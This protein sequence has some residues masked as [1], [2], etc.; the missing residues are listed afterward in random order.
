MKSFK[1]TRKYFSGYSLQ[2][3]IYFS[4]LLLLLCTFV[5]AQQVII[6][7]KV[8]VGDS[9]LADVTVSVRNS[10]IATKTNETGF[11]S[12]QVPSN[13][14]LVF[15]SVG[16]VTKEVRV[17]S[18]SVIN[19]ELEFQS[20]QLNDVIVVGYGTQ[21]KGNI[22]GSVSSIKSDE[23][24]RT[25]AS[26]TSSAIVGRVAGI[27]A[28]QATGRPGQGTSIQIRNLGTPLYV[29]DGVPQSEGQFNNVSSEDIESISI[30]KDGSAALYGVRASNGVVLVTT[31]KGKSGDKGKLSVNTYYQLQNLTRYLSASDAYTH[32]RASAEAQ[33][34]TNTLAN[35]GGINGGLVT[36]TPAELEKWR[37][38]TDSGYRSTNYR[39]Y[40]LQKNAPQKYIN[41]NASGGNDRMNYYVSL[42]ALSQEGIVN[43]FDFKRYN[44][45]T[46]VEGTII[47]GVKFGAQLNGRVEGRYNPA[48][49]TNADAYD[50]PFLAILTTWPMERIYANDN[51][52]YINGAVHRPDRNPANFDRNV[53][54]TQD[55]VWN[56]FGSIFYTTIEL[57]FGFSAKATYSYNYKQNKNEVFRKNF[58]IYTYDK[59]TGEYKV[60]TTQALLRRNKSRQEI[61]EN[62]TAFQL[63]YNKRI[64]K[65]TISATGAYEYATE[66]D[67]F[68]AITSSPA[69]N[70]L[71][72]IRTQDVTA[73]DNSYIETKR[74]SVIGRFNYD[75]R[76]RYLFEVL[77][78]YDGNYIYPPG[79]RWGLFPGVTGGWVLSEEK[80]YGDKLKG[81]MNY[82]KLRA[83]WGRTGNVVGV[84][85]FDYLIGG[86][87]PSGNYV[88]ADGSVINGV[89]I[90]SLPITNI[91]WVKSTIKNIGIQLGFFNHKLTAEF[92]AFSRDLTGIPA[93]KVDVVVPVEVGYTLPNE[94][95]DSDRTLGIEGTITYTNRIGEVNYSVSGNATLARRKNLERYKPRFGNSWDQ[96][97]NQSDHRWADINW[98]YEVTGQFQS[99]EEIK[100]Y[101]INNDGQGNTTQLPGDLK[102]RDVNGD[103]VITN[104]DER[105][106]GYGGNNGG[107]FGGNNPYMSFGLNMSF[108][109]K[110][111]GINLDWTGATLQSY[112]RIFESVVP[113]QATH[114]GPEYLFND[115][116]HRE[117]LYDNN[118]AW[119][120]G[121]YPAIRRINNHINYT[122]RSDFWI[123][124]ISYLRLR[125][126]ELVYNLPK[127]ILSRVHLSGA[128][129]YVTGTNILTFD[130]MKDIEL[131]PEIGQNNGLVYP[132]MKLYTFGINL[133]L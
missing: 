78:R 69:N 126:L 39:D 28:R 75:Y 63:N 64:G 1:L 74:G 109:Y 117:D 91:T 20:L 16:F 70:Y 9:A 57:P 83:S 99:V 43:Q 100:N 81:I 119:L 79:K 30:L 23:I 112:Y 12:I 94:N 102:F 114:N 25:P 34:N 72:V 59:T 47:K 82:V 37:L 40:I 128:K 17:G 73:I 110:G 60:K 62:F 31:R 104:L 32:M 19:T 95:L 116:W 54:G 67:E 18:S 124:N 36:I 129:V 26:T 121:K 108:S 27:T 50:N 2:K 105:P 77:G 65:H 49:T 5:S 46:N 13:S 130:N 6:T 51:P 10:T 58:D 15:T 80:F 106:I 14:T 71:P 22:T 38:G 21:R 48:S 118:S 11:Y 122:R 92:D 76:R 61:K 93:P 111:F 96:Y 3:S 56:N 68:V 53:V 7:G 133:T 8:V 115:R 101:T 132:I 84:S 89:G 88:M 44:F 103:G 123:K 90:R 98:G 97:R 33:Q 41:I 87:F 131:D 113:F 127:S 55:N 120:P 107:T 66:I 85:P 4:I 29:I 24:M 125:N 86:N 42:G 35:G 52:N 45:Q